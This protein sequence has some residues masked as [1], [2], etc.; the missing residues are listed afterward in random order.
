MFQGFRVLGFR[1]LLG[2]LKKNSMLLYHPKLHV[3]LRAQF[4]FFFT[5]YVLRPKQSW[6]RVRVSGLGVEGFGCR[7]LGPE[8]E[9]GAQTFP[10]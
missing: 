10:T 7:V 2:F 6:F 1:A 9:Q 5:N 8:S 4:S 3:R